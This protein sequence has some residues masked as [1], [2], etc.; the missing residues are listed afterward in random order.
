MGVWDM[1]YLIQ[2]YKKALEHADNPSFSPETRAE[3]C[4][5]AE[6]LRAQMA[7]YLERV[8]AGNLRHADLDN[9]ESSK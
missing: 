6:Q 9:Q 2:K 5:K 7:R 8:E 1:L 3:F 4:A